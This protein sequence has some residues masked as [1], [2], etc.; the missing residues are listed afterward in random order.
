MPVEHLDHFL[1]SPADY[2]LD[3]RLQL[4]MIEVFYPG[5]LLRIARLPVGKRH[6]LNVFRFEQELERSVVIDSKDSV[7]IVRI[8]FDIPSDMRIPAEIDVK[9]VVCS[10]GSEQSDVQSGSLQ[11][12]L[13]SGLSS[14][15]QQILLLCQWQS[16]VFRCLAP[17][18]HKLGPFLPALYL[19]DPADLLAA[20]GFIRKASFHSVQRI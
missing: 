14:E 15:C 13:I 1:L 3:F 19:Y 18:G 2:R 10:F 4:L 7:E 20:S 8:I 12:V 9:A 11:C 16:A 6:R 5:K 17:S